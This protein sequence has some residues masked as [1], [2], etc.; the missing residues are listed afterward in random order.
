MGPGD[1]AVVLVRPSESGNIGAVCRAMANMGLGDL[2]IVAPECVPDEAVIRARAV[3]AENVWDKARHFSSLEDALADRSLVIG[4]TRRMGQR[5]KSV[6]ITPRETAEYLSGKDGTAALVFG[7]ERTGLTRDELALCTL[8]SHIPA[9]DDFPSLN[10]S[11]AVQ[12][13]AYELYTALGPP[14]GKRWAPMDRKAADEVTASVSA[15][16]ETLG[17]YKQ[18]GREE[19]ERFFRDLFSRAGLTIREGRYVKAIFTKIAWLG[20]K[21]RTPQ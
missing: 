12:V 17:F 21:N 6:T 8:A 10:L 2:R 16:L 11:H 20:G 13:Y 14:P 1:I 4:T 7:N 19:Q 18:Q 15:S 5:R 9:C 3:H